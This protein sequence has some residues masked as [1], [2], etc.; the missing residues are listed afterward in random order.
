MTRDL[1]QSQTMPLSFVN[2]GD[3]VS[4]I[5]I[6]AGDRLRRRL[7]ALGL[8]VGMT[9]R[10]VQSDMSGPMILAV[11]NDSRLAIGHGMAQKI[12]VTPSEKESA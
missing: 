1:E 3:T 10:V 9:V 6:R 7:N 12:M 8:N 11:A 2:A 5:E 4:L